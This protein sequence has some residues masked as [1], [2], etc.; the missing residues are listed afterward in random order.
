MSTVFYDAIFLSVQD[1][2]NATWL[3]DRDPFF[4]PNDG[5][6]TDTEFQNDCLAYTLFNGQ[7]RISSREGT[8]H[9]IPFTEQEV[10]AQEKFASNFMSNFI[11]G[12]HT[13]N[14]TNIGQQNSL[15]ETARIDNFQKVVNSEPQK[16]VNSEP[17][18]IVNIKLEFSAEAQAVFNAGKELWRYYHSSQFPSNGGV[19]G[20][21]NVN[22]SLY[23]IR[24]YFQGRNDKGRMN[25]KSTDETYTILIAALRDCLKILAK[26]IEPKVYD[27]EFL[28]A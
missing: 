20:G 21:Y 24:E 26:K 4:F 23:D 11:Q 14:T 7:N 10:N 27:Y 1:A 17:Q 3:N 2:I 22:A 25:A 13:P 9:W 12:K 5:W 8:N 19:R 6:Q 28:K 18:K 16:N 15:F